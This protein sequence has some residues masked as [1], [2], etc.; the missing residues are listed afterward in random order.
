ML[1]PKELPIIGVLECSHSLFKDYILAMIA[2]I[3]ELVVQRRMK[4]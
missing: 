1:Q 3:L 4:E 2:I